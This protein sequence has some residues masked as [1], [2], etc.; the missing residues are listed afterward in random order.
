[1]LL[2]FGL[3]ALEHL[4]LIFT[5]ATGI[6]RLRQRKQ[7]KEGRELHMMALLILL[8]QKIGNAIGLNTSLKR[9]QQAQQVL[10]SIF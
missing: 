2:A 8:W 1:M 10:L 9:S 7:A 6:C 3:K 4:Q 5:E